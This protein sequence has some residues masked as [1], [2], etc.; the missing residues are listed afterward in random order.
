MKN[1]LI[2]LT[3]L[4]TGAAIGSV[5]TWKLVKT[6]Y[7]KI[8][9]EEIAS[10][11]EEFSKQRKPVVKDENEEVEE[12]KNEETPSP[13][14][15]E[16]PN[17]MEYAA[18]IRKEGYMDYSNSSKSEPKKEKT[19]YTRDMDDFA[20]DPEPYVIAPEHFDEYDDYE[21]V[22]LTYWADDYLTDEDEN[23]I[24]DIDGMVG[25]DYADHF[26]EFEDDSVFIRNERLK[27]DFEILA[28]ESNYMDTIKVTPVKVEG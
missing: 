3:M 1:T 5:V 27:T 2:N 20:Y 6:K 8:A 23:L 9:E 19:G 26:G 13:R 18:M 10:V 25:L 28:V 11:K 7:E 21:A 4:V 24:E 17:I 15:A 14:V 12:V 22:S 16:K